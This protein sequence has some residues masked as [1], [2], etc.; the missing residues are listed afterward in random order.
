M[1][2]NDIKKILYK[3]KPSAKL[4]FKSETAVVYQATTSVGTLLFEVPVSEAKNFNNDEPAQLL[5]R[6][7][8][9]PQNDTTQ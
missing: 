6:W 8:V 4:S 2:T 1:N 9:I 7:L 3:E 5:I